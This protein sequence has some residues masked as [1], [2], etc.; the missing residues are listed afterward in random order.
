MYSNYR[1]Q[2]TTISSSDSESDVEEALTMGVEAALRLRSSELSRGNMVPVNVA[3]TVPSHISA[4]VAHDIHIESARVHSSSPQRVRQVPG[5]EKLGMLARPRQKQGTA[6][7]IH[8][9]QNSMSR[10][11]IMSYRKSVREMHQVPVFRSDVPDVT[12]EDNLQRGLGVSGGLR[13]SSAKITKDDVEVMLDELARVKIAED[14]EV[15][16]TPSE[17]T[18]SLKQHQREG[19]A[20]MVRN[21]MN[22]K[23]RGGI[24]GDDMGLGKTVQALALLMAHKPRVGEK[25]GT[26]VV[27]PVATLNHWKNEAETRFKPGTLS[28]LV[29]YGSNRERFDDVLGDYDLVIT[30]IGNVASGW[31]ADSTPRVFDLSEHD[32]ELR[33]NSSLAASSCALFRVRW[34]RIIVDEAH[35][36]RNRKSKK[37]MACCDLVAQYRWCLSGTPIQNSLEDAYSLLRFLRIQPYCKLRMFRDLESREDRGMGVVRTILSSLMLRRRKVIVAKTTQLELPVRYSYNHRVSLAPAERVCYFLLAR[38]GTSMASWLSRAS[39]QEMLSKLGLLRQAASHPAIANASAG[40]VSGA[41]V[42]GV[43]LD[44]KLSTFASTMTLQMD[45]GA[46]MP[47]MCGS[48]AG[49]FCGYCTRDIDFTCEFNV[50]V[51]GGYLCSECAKG[52][53][54]DRRCSTCLS[55]K[56]A[57]DPKSWIRMHAASS[58]GIKLDNQVIER[59]NQQYLGLN[60]APSSKMERILQILKSVDK[61]CKSDKVVIFTEHLEFIAIASPYLA[62]NGFPNLPYTGSMTKPKRDKAIEDF[63]SDPSLRVLLVSKKAGNVGI[64]LTMANHVIVESVWW[65]PAVDG[66]AVD[67][68]YR[69]GQTKPVHVHVLISKGTV[70]EKV[71]DIQEAKRQ[72]INSAVNDDTSAKAVT[73]RRDDLVNIFRSIHS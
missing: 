53:K 18:V 63:A 1:E 72:L 40:A 47:P 22:V 23:R 58:N 13:R 56:P 5:K 17:M 59:I 10:E 25:H 52:G 19:V 9:P 70:E 28:V 73:L 24:L 64:N 37:S 62:K 60:A 2:P 67:R 31:E 54:L 32:R 8:V 27:A 4:S 43:R 48:G 39:Y 38:F 26:L 57:V 16:D 49:A 20:W 45:D 11:Q 68:V 66:Q 65:N 3:R 6:T 34:R 61:H 36:L 30:S 46:V 35:E 14:E 71:Y 55:E 33:D 29:Y 21:E 42:P 7:P 50:H 41:L 15:V 44:I 69:I 51:C 12:S